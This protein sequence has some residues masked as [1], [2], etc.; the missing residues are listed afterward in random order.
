MTLTS[1]GIAEI[2]VGATP[3]RARHFRLE[4]GPRSREI[5]FDDQGRVLRVEIPAL[6]FVADRE[7]LT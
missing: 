7:G 3:V 2:R 6:G 5:W 4:G 1:L